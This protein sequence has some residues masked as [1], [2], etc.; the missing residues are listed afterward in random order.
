MQ[1]HRN[2]LISYD[3]IIQSTDYSFVDFML[4]SLDWKKHGFKFEDLLRCM[5]KKER[6][7]FI[8]NRPEEDLFIFL[9]D[10]KYNISNISSLGIDINQY[11]EAYFMDII[12]S[13]FGNKLPLL[14]SNNS[15]DKL[16]ISVDISNVNKLNILTYILGDY[17]DKVIICD[18]GK[19]DDYIKLS[20]INTIFT[21]DAELKPFIGQDFLN[22]K[23]IMI[24]DNEYI[25][26]WLNT[27]FLSKGSKA[28]LT[29]S[30]WEITGLDI[31]FIKPFNYNIRKV[32][33]L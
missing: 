32:N 22:N 1:E 4:N 14:L 16:Y 18:I 6:L 11:S 5:T 3:N 25:Y 8:N 29:K 2:M 10:G 21:N 33:I 31:S 9:S 24:N 12:I 20:N 30:E 27:D 19:F 17:S 7:Y 23:S 28:K 15:I 13:D 26:Y